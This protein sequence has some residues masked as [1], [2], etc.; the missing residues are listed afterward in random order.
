M[1]KIKK[2]FKYF[3]YKI[4]AKY[5]K[6][7]G[8]H[9]PFLYHFVRENLYG[10]RYFYAFDDIAELRYDL[11]CSDEKISVTD[12]GVGSEKM[13]DNIRKVR[14]IAKYSAVSEKFGEMLFKTV[15]Y[16]KPKTILEL[17]T[18]LGIGTLYLALPD[19][20]A[21][22]Y[23][24][25]GCP[26]TAKKASD[27]FKELNVKNIKQLIG[28]INDKLPELLNGIDKLD[29][30]YFDGNHR[31]DA[32]LNYFYQCLTKAHNDTIFYFD[33]IH[34]SEGMEEAWKEIKK[35]EKVTLTVDLFFSGIVFFRKELSKEDFTVNF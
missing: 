16:Y 18:S 20:K 31:K 28:N 29:F 27:N 32:T 11:L 6:G 21:T 9:S 8:V 14:D 33:D 30:V 4:F 35:N 22:I 15:E 3:K 5:R 2:I 19:S 7:Y 25:E 34:L 12:F 24:I 26:E 17:G 10:N 23:T 13:K 1:Q